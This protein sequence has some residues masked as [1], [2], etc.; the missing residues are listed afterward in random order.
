MF[1][2]YGCSD[3]LELFQK[4]WKNKQEF[5]MF[6]CLC[7][8]EESFL[9]AMNCMTYSRFMSLENLKNLVQDSLITACSIECDVNCFMIDVDH[10]NNGSDT[11]LWFTSRLERLCSQ[12][13]VR[14]I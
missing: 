9:L 14:A 5:Q 10:A 2:R 7:D 13:S 1:V 11:S 4:E 3:S 6:F 12:P 8:S